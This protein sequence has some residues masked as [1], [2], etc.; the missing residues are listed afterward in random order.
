MIAK[1]ILV[2]ALVAYAEA[3]FGQE[4]IPISAIS[5]VQGGDAGEAATIAGAAISDLLGAANAC[6]KLVRADQVFT[7]LGPGADA[8]AA[9]IGLVTAEKNTN[10]FAN[11]NVQ[12]V[13]DDPGLPA[14]PELRGITPLIDPDV[15]G[16]DAVIAF[17]AQ[18]AASPVDATG[19]SV[20][21]L[22]VDA[23]LGDSVAAQVGAGGAVAAPAA[24]AAGGAD[25]EEEVDE[26]EEDVD[27][28]Q[29]QEEVVAACP[30]IA[31]A[32]AANATEDADQQQEAD[33]QQQQEGDDQQQEAD[34]Q[35]QAVGAGGEDFGLCT[36]T[37]I[38]EAGLN[39]RDADEFTFQIA[40]ELA[41]GGQGEALNPNIITNALCN[42]LTNVCEANDA[43][44]ALCLE[45]KAVVAGLTERNK[46]TA[47]AF[48]TAIG[49]PGAVTNPSGGPADVGEVARKMRRARV[50]RRGLRI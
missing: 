41:R 43:A 36:P 21:Q 38:F 1:S 4:Q 3:R 30:P 17:S 2:A 5:A 48:N 10:P 9:A 12:N 26:V 31:A 37:I 22:L 15:A 13:C 39:G 24:P 32:P 27:E 6:A 23:G 46:A 50:M 28:E 29:D 19:K 35:Q 7:E 16:A 40:D 42:Q 47:D 33:D 20:F 45:A 18:T 49:F 14:T 11:G 8:L 44:I 34:D 25:D